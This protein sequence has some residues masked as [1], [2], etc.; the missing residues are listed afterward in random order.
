MA[1]NHRS[2]PSL[3]W[4]EVARFW[5]Q[6]DVGPGKDC[7]NWRG[8]SV[9]DGYGM[10]WIRGHTY[11]ANRVAWRIVHG[12]IPQGLVIM[13][14][15]DNPPCCNLGHLKVATDLENNTD[16]VRKGRGAVGDRHGSRTQPEQWYRNRV[17]SGSAILTAVDVQEIRKRYAQGQVTQ[18]RLAD[19]YGLSQTTIS[20]IIR[21]KQWKHLPV[22][23]Q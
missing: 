10:F 9:P 18:Q 11:R 21:R 22:L 15:C 13:H 7:W 8:A 16:K 2:I 4:Q 6:V 3:T 20:G 14:V 1:M 5:S 12:P 19:E 17:V 23:V